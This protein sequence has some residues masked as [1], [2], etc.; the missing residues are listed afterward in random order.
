MGR[1]GGCSSSSTYTIL[2]HSPVLLVGVAVAVVV[3]GHQTYYCH[4]K[5]Q[6]IK[7]KRNKLSQTQTT[8]KINKLQQIVNYRMN[9]NFVAL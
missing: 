4:A 2:I 7:W 6:K 5:S 3:A 8:S 9:D 1:R